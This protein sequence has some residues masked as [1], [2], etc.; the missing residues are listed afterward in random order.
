MLEDSAMALGLN[1]VAYTLAYRPL[2]RYLSRPPE[3]RAE[4]PKPGGFVFAQVRYQGE[5]NPDPGAF[6]NLLRSLSTR[7]HVKVALQHPFVPLNDAKLSDYPF[8]YMTGHGPFVF[9][10][11]ELEGLGTFLRAGGF[12]LA[13]A[14]CGDLEF[15]QH[16]RRLLGS[17]FPDKELVRIPEDDPLFHAP[18][19]IG[20]V[21]YSPRVGASWPSLQKPLLEGI[22]MEG[23]WRVVYSRFD[24][25]CG[26]EGEE[27]PYRLAYK[28]EDAIRI[29]LNIV[30][31]A[32]TH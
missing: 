26:F 9:S 31:Y 4:D 13:D 12:L 10:K 23:A 20:T 6:S 22:S 18:E 29:T 30:V 16:F 28:D 17:L 1:M 3:A 27:H 11:E 7:T 24:L 21:S 15:D 25:G 5:Y 32:M 2:G 8:L 19:K 14:C